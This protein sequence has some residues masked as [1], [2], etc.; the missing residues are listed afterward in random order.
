MF[1]PEQCEENNLRDLFAAAVKNDTGT[2]VGH[3]PRTIS[4]VC[5]LFLRWGGTTVCEVTGNRW[6]S[7]DLPQGL[8]CRLLFLALQD[9]LHLCISR[10]DRGWWYVF[11]KCSLGVWQFLNLAQFAKIVKRAVLLVVWCLATPRMM[12][13]TPN[14]R[15]A[16]FSRFG[17]HLRKTREFSSKVWSHTVYVRNWTS[18][19]STVKCTVKR[20]KSAF[21]SFAKLKIEICPQVVRFCKYCH[22]WFTTCVTFHGVY[23][24]T[25]PQIS[26]ISLN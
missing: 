15:G 6:A 5:S 4:V 16:Q 14:F 23:P 11:S 7:V 10:R 9:V 18:Y 8:L 24:W 17:D 22:N 19:R 21:R 12:W 2:V 26:H 3:V 13:I 20:R 25:N 1:S